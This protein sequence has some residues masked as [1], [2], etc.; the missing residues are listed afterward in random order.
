MYK[1]W[2][3]QHLLVGN[4]CKTAGSINELLPSVICEPQNSNEV[5]CTEAKAHCEIGFVSLET[6]RK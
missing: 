1:N 2:C 5:T 3:E 4:C 6:I